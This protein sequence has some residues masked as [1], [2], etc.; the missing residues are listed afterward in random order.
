MLNSSLGGSMDFI[1]RWLGMAPDGGNGGVELAIL[2]TL[3]GVVLA[4]VLWRRRQ[5]LRLV[6][7]ARVRIK[8]RS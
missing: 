5:R 7:R 6:R 1:E 3:G 8:V 4:A 2:M